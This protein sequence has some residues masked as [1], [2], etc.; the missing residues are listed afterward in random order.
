MKIFHFKWKDKKNSP[1]GYNRQPTAYFPYYKNT[2]N[3]SNNDVVM[4]ET[5]SHNIEECEYPV[6][7]VPEIFASLKYYPYKYTISSV[8]GFLTNRP[9]LYFD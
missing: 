7:G 4:P 1:S 8:A 5:S 9:M 3:L 6:S 2:A